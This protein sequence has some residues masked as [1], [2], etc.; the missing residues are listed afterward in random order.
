MS[1]IFVP[2]IIPY[3]KNF[4]PILSPDRGSEAIKVQRFTL[5]GREL[6]EK[7]REKKRKDSEI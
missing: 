4:M 6:G 3:V 5:K 1:Q 2:H 7:H